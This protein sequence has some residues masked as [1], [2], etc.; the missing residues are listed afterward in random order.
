MSNKSDIVENNLKSTKPSLK[1]VDD[2]KLNFTISSVEIKD[3]PKI[4]IKL[5]SDKKSS[6][7]SKDD[8]KLYDENENINDFEVVKNGDNISII[9]IFPIFDSNSLTRNI[10]I[11]NVN[12]ENDV[13]SATY[14]KPNQSQALLNIT[15]VDS[16]DYPNIKLYFTVKD[17]NNNIIKN[18]NVTNINLYEDNNV[19]LGREISN[20]EYL[21]NN[22]SISINLVMDTSGSMSDNIKECK[23]IAIDFLNNMDLSSGDRVEF[24]EFNDIA[25]INNYFT[26]NKQSLINSINS[27]STDGGTALY[28]SLIMALNQTNLEEGAK[29]VIA[30]TDG[31]DNSS[32]NREQDV[33]NLSQNLDIPIY[34]IGLGQDLGNSL[35][36][37]CNSTGGKLITI[38]N[39]SELKEIY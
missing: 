28:D 35:S 19:S 27:I 29:C 22:E 18:L 34:I 30:F 6:E 17:I 39:I 32:L 23:N 37:I 33:I 16:N 36:N 12:E 11:E 8:I 5:K 26:S 1:K 13:L 38:S 9:Y 25:K 14:T 20:L 31:L 7:L 10:K 4:E 2:K 21:E 15:Q 24:I 3:F